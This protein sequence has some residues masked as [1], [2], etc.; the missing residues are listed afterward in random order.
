MERRAAPS[1]LLAGLAALVFS[2]PVANAAGFDCKKAKS[3]LEKTI[4]DDPDLNSLDSQLS[5]AFAGAL[6]RVNDKDAVRRTERAFLA[7]REGKTLK[8]LQDAYR[9]RIADLSK[10]AD[11][12]QACKGQGT[13]PEIEACASEYSRRAD[14]R[15]TR[16]FEA[17]RRRLK[18]EVADNSKVSAEALSDLEASQAA[19]ALYR[20]AECKAV[21][22]WWSEGTIRGLE[23]ATC[24]RALTETRTLT[25]WDNWLQFEDSTPPLLPKPVPEK[26]S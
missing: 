8:A 24:Y 11:E 2:A 20:E 9:A 4:C 6:D 18:D 3:A 7:S 13:T 25:L 12:P 23:Y 1:L 22:Q 21:Y 5:E 15:L 26:G 14:A 10:T 17:A 19:F 16:Y